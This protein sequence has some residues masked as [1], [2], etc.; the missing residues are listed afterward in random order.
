[1]PG[2][3]HAFGVHCN[4]YCGYPRIPA[5]GPNGLQPATWGEALSAVAAASKGLRGTQLKAVAGKLADAESMV[6]LKVG[7]KRGYR[8]LGKQRLCVPI[9]R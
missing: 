4:P 6:A 9:P 8:G 7:F 2:L 5:Q 3:K 1:M